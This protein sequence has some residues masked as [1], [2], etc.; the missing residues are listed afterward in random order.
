MAHGMPICL[1]PI[2]TDVVN[3]LSMQPIS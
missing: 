3:V 1:T 2:D